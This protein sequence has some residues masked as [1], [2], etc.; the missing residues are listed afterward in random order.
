MRASRI[1][2]S[3]A[4]GRSSARQNRSQRI[5]HLGKHPAA[6]CA[7]S[8]NYKPAWRGS[9][10]PGGKGKKPSPSKSTNARKDCK[11]T[12]GRQT[13]QSPVGV[14]RRFDHEDH[15]SLCGRC[16]VQKLP[17]GPP[18]P[19][20]GV[21]STVP[22]FQ[23]DQESTLHHIKKKEKKNFPPK[24]QKWS[25]GPVPGVGFGVFGQ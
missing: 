20:R 7:S 24:T 9:I 11:L 1:T 4:T 2:S 8:E 19:C 12:A 10:L 23:V 18:K 5:N 14:I 13:R 3:S 16:A 6:P 25:K 17:W 22:I 15:G 21:S